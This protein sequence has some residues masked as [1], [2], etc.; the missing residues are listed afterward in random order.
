M[1]T[2]YARRWDD[3]KNMAITKHDSQRRVGSELQ[4]AK[5]KAKLFHF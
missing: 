1:I 5:A 4:L 3:W 2:N